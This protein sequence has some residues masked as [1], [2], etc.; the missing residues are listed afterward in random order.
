M[1]DVDTFLTILYVM[2]DDLYHYR[3]PKRIRTPFGEVR[4]I[5]LPRTSVNKRASEVRIPQS[6]LPLL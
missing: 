3:R 1:L 5:S 6:Y 2:V 4:R